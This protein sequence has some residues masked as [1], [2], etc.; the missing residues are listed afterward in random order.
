MFKFFFL[1][2]FFVSKIESSK[3]LNIRIGFSFFP[4]FSRQFGIVVTFLVECVSVF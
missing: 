3:E 4:Y 2:I 1:F